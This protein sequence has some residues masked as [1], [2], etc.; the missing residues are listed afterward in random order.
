MS[1]TR[2]LSPAPDTPAG[3][4]VNASRCRPYCERPCRPSG[5]ALSRPGG[6]GGDVRH[7][8]S[9]A[10]SAACGP[11]ATGR[12]ARPEPSPHPPS[13]SQETS[14]R[15]QRGG[16]AV[17]PGFQRPPSPAVVRCSHARAQAAWRASPSPGLHLQLV[18][19]ET[20]ARCFHGVM[21]ASDKSLDLT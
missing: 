16:S 5:P 15:G 11:A 14:L 3:R 12:C 7:S 19:S 18:R 2:F 20:T 8:C 17:E 9:T 1:R 21:V 10:E 13:C 4:E 6:S